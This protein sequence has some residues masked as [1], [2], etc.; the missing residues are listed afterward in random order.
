MPIVPYACTN[1]R[2]SS[3]WDAAFAA[4]VVLVEPQLRVLRSCDSGFVDSVGP[5]AMREG[6][7]G[8]TQVT[9]R[10]EKREM[11]P[12]DTGV[13]DRNMEALKNTTTC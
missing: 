12:Q 13:G 3:R 2:V 4:L 6:S 7:R 5:T 10:G 11:K 1:D 8:R 9:G